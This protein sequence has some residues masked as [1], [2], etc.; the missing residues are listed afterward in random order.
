ME[1]S[2]SFAIDPSKFW[3]EFGH[4]VLHVRNAHQFE[5]KYCKALALRQVL[6]PGA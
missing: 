6:S 3:G 5:C 4:E 2:T 1:L